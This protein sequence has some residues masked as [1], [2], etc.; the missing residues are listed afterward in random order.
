M[1]AD[2]TKYKAKNHDLGS[3]S[4][5]K[6]RKPTAIPGVTVRVPPPAPNYRFLD[7]GFFRYSR[8]PKQEPAIPRDLHPSAQDALRVANRRFRELT[9]SSNGLHLTSALRSAERQLGLYI[10]YAHFQYGGPPADVANPSGKSHHH[11]GLAIDVSLKSNSR[12]SIKALNEAGW[13]QT[14]MPQDPVH[15][16][17]AS[18]RAYAAMV[19]AVVRMSSAS[20]KIRSSVSGYLNARSIHLCCRQQYDDLRTKFIEA[21]EPRKK[22][23]KQLRAKRKGIL[24]KAKTI[25]GRLNRL[26]STRR[27]ILEAR[28]KVNAMKYNRCPNKKVFRSCT[29]SDRKNAWCQEKIQRIDDYEDAVVR[30]RDDFRRL[31]QRAETLNSEISI[32][33]AEIAELRRTASQRNPD[34]VEA[35]RLRRRLQSTLRTMRSRWVKLRPQLVAIQK[36]IDSERRAIYEL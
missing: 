20:D 2:C 18:T 21:E 5:I 26:K 30:Y 23:L 4:K 16:E 29:H 15:F 8:S 10:D 32:F 6:V 31:G 13:K 33:A 3:P 34:R 28:S 25:N 9:G 1:V 11:F 22:K 27:K 14:I 24:R 36:T 35:R 19:A 12:A 7:K 17:F